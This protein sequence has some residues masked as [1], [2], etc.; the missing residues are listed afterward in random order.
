MAGAKD[1]GR[2]KFYAGICRAAFRVDA[3]VLDSGIKSGIEQFALRRSK[4]SNE[5][6]IIC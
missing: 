6:R 1:S 3:V 4:V 5:Q 2:A